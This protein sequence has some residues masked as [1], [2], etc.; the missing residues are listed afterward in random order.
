[1]RPAP[2]VTV[3]IMQSSHP[4]ITPQGLQGVVIDGDLLFGQQFADRAVA[5]APG[6]SPAAV[7]ASPPMPI[8]QS[9]GGPTMMSRP[10]SCP[11]EDTGPCISLDDHNPPFL[12][13]NFNLR[14][15]QQVC[16]PPPPAH[17]PRLPVSTVLEAYC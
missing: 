7:Y 12:N 16:P 9:P 13:E 5:V 4:D 6:P 17:P 11:P 10:F 2:A 3:L 15:L 1:M 14:S 8:W